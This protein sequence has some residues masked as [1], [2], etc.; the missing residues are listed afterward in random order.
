MKILNII[1]KMFILLSLFIVIVGCSLGQET[2]TGNVTIITPA[3][4]PITKSLAGIS[5]HGTLLN[6]NQDLIRYEIGVENEGRR[7]ASIQLKNNVETTIT[8][9]AGIKLDFGVG[10]YL[11][12]SK[13]TNNELWN[14]YVLSDV[15]RNIVLMPNETL[16][17]DFTLDYSKPTI[18][19]AYFPITGVPQLTEAPGIAEMT[20]GVVFPADILPATFPVFSYTNLNTNVSK[21][22]Y[23]N[24]TTETFV[25]LNLLVDS[26]VPGPPT[27]AG[28]IFKVV[29]NDGEMFWIIDDND[30]FSNPGDNGIFNNNTFLGVPLEYKYP[31]DR[32]PLSSVYEIRSIKHST[33]TPARDRYWYFLNYG[34]GMLSVKYDSR[35]TKPPNL[36][37]WKKITNIDFT[38]FDYIY[39]NEPFI[40]DVE[41]DT[42]P[43]T[44]NA[45]FAT[46][47]GAF[48]IGEDAFDAFADGD[49]DKGVALLKK[50]FR[51][52]DPVDNRRSVL[53]T[54]IRIY[55]NNIY[56]A[57]RAG[58]F[59]IKRN[60]S[61]WQKFRDE[62]IT[63]SFMAFP[64]EE[65]ELVQTFY[66]EPIISV[67]LAGTNNDILVV[68]T[69]RRVWFK[70]E[71]NGKTDT[72]TVWDGI[73]F[74][75]MKS[76]SNSDPVNYADYRV[77]DTAPIRYVL[78]D[79]TNSK[80]WIGTTF[81]L[82]S[83]NLSKLF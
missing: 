34:Q 52:T 72:I 77:H 63:G 38:N 70:N 40:M 76:F 66:H 58:L 32:D 39:P 13:N 45:F 61:A 65:I 11:A 69:P 46:K 82:S 28:K 26:G 7:I 1:T 49:K 35:P 43:D 53:I 78:W 55:G 79:E 36:P 27:G 57:S 60:T 25:N 50:I 8:V 9:P 71:S 54:G 24:G 42:S 19:Q 15:K 14:T 68:V 5:D 20:G 48:Y 56:L 18:V 17:L 33:T 75:P 81:G 31:E 12:E 51:I 23:Y 67:E 64:E 29:S 6:D 73:S 59:R 83:V 74:I 47:I 37:E 41:Q 22:V 30:I 16:Y 21:L 10:I 2:E 4:A 62:P 3:Y 80:F 44:N